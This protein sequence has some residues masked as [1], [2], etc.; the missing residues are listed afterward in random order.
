MIKSTHFKYICIHACNLAAQSRYRVFASL[1]KVPLCHSPGTSSLNPHPIACLT[2][3][4]PCSPFCHYRFVYIRGPQT[5]A[6]RPGLAY[7][8]FS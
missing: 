5:M 7:C 4:N 1:P 2:V 6:R 3:G 8:L